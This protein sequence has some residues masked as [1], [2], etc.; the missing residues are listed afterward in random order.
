MTLSSIKANC[1]PVESCRPQV[2]QEKQA[3]WNTRSRAFRTQSEGAIDREHLEHLAP[4][5]LKEVTEKMGGM[6]LDYINHLQFYSV[7]KSRT[8]LSPPLVSGVRF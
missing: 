7:M 6:L 8:W 3:R 5:V 4:K 2:S 1:S